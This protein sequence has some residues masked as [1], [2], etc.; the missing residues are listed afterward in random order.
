[1]AR[2]VVSFPTSGRPIYAGN[3]DGMPVRFD[4]GKVTATDVELAR[5]VLPTFSYIHSLPFKLGDDGV[6]AEVA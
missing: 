3:L 6:R 5:Y 1:M 4:H 2:W